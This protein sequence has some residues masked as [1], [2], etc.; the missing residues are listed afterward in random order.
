MFLPNISEAKIVSKKTYINLLLFV[1]SL[2]VDFFSM[3]ILKLYEN[4]YNG[5]KGIKC[6]REMHARLNN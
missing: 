5:G 1:A 3:L 4:I 6:V 2:I